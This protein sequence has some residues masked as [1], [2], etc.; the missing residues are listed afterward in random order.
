VCGSIDQDL[1]GAVSEKGP[2]VLDRP[3]ATA[4]RER[5]EAGLRRAAH[6][7]EQGAAVLM[8]CANVQEAQLVSA[9]GIICFGGLDRVACVHEVDELH[10]LDHAAVLHVE[11]GDDADLEHWLL[12]RG[13]VGDAAEDGGHG[14]LDA[15]AAE[16][17]GVL[18]P[19]Q[20]GR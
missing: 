19:G 5:H 4:H 11:T 13:G 15:E 14:K 2:H 8:A 17:D 12:D 1:V 6:H 20:L 3:N 16:G 10:A 9:G 18:A 7:V